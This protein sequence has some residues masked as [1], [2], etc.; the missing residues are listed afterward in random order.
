MWR[1]GLAAVATA[2]VLRALRA[3]AASAPRA[4]RPEPA[5]VPFERRL[6]RLLVL[7]ALG[8]LVFLSAMNL[9]VAGAGATVTAFVAG[10]YAVLGAL[11]GWPILGERLTAD[12]IVGFVVALAGTALLAELDPGRASG[13]IVAGLAAAVSYAFFLVLSRR[14][15]R[16]MALD[17]WTISL[18]NNVFA[19]IGLLGL[20]AV[21]GSA[22]TIVPSGVRVDALVAMAW[23]ALVAVVAQVLVVAA[24]RR[25][26]AQRSSAFLLLNPLSATVLGAVLL[27]ER[28]TAG[29]LVGGALVILGMAIGTGTF[30]A[31]RELV[32]SDAPT[33]SRA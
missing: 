5:A 27:G 23:L 6:A 3:R 18:A 4:V 28:L 14:W 20:L 31:V 33:A 21:A 32:A 19:S 12:A 2:V 30:G 29:Q 7:G 1:S 10:L 13:G 11:L 15:S 26:D 8:G 16:P 9:A 25:V 24:V 22:S 17:P